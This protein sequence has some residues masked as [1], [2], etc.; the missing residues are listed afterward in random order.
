MNRFETKQRSLNACLI[1][2]VAHLCIAI[3]LTFF[4]YTQISNDFE[5]VVGVEFVDMKDPAKQK[6]QLKRPPPKQLLTPKQ[7]KSLTGGRPKHVALTTSS[8]LID[9]TVRPSEKVLMHS[10]TESVS[11]TATNLPEL[12]TQTEQLNSRTA[13]LP[14]NVSSPFEITSGAGKESLRQRVKGDGKSGFNRLESTGAADIGTIGEGIGQG[15]DGG[16]GKGIGKGNKDASNPFAEALK[17]IADHIIATRTLDKVNVVF[18]LDTSKSMGDN[19]QQVAENLFS[20]TDAFDLV[21]IEY[22]LGMSEFSVREGGQELET[23]SLAPDVGY[24]RRRMQKVKLS[25]DEN[26]LDALIDTLNYMDFHP[27]ADKHLI[28]VT[29][30]V[31]TTS[32]REKGAPDTMRAKVIDQSQMEDIHVNVL[33]FPEPFQQELATTTDGVWKEIPGSAYSPTALPTNRAGN[34][35]FLKVFRDIATAIRRSGGKLFF[36]L[37]LKFD[38]LVE[39]REIPINKLQQAFKENGVDL[40]NYTFRTE[41]VTVLEKHQNDLWVITD[42]KNGQIFAIHRIENRLNVYAGI[43]PKNWNLDAN[44]T[45]RTQQQDRKWTLTDSRNNQ[46]YTFLKDRNR[47][48]IYTGGQPGTASNNN[49]APIVDIVVMLDYSRSMGGKSQAIMLGL[50]NLI[51]RLS[52]FSLKY[53]IGLIRFAEAKDA[54]KVIDGAVVTQMPLNEVLIES[55]MEDPFGGDE[56]LID[57]I[58]EGLPEVKFSPYAKRFL[59]ILTDEPT[60]GKYPAEQALQLCQ[61]LGITAYVIGHPNPT[62]FQTTLATQ[63]G[64]VFFPMPRHLEK[65]YPNQ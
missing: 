51:G 37:E 9:E 44:L 43:Y 23:R 15:G 63:T 29:D 31:A 61:S 34:Q 20:M 21:N 32:L 45:A 54:I 47:L 10:A 39:E 49:A 24:L 35:K 12:T 4:Y 11:K 65:A 53:R 38:M 41:N 2:G 42:K 28:L 64:G 60:T 55:L 25:G 36:S 14:K 6:R 18:V 46:V 8:N 17:Q 5:D 33:G 50:S 58:V 40:K 22:H 19:I 48:N 62:D 3:F 30:E 16:N 57:A 1:A 52:I 13:A 56:H 26:A 59:L 7:T 27:D